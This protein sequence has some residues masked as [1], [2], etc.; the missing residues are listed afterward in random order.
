MPVGVLMS[1][2]IAEIYHYSLRISNKRIKRKRSSL[3]WCRAA[4]PGK[5]AIK[6]K[7]FKTQLRDSGLVGVRTGSGSKV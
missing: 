1:V 7:M 4:S 3:I 6:K 5:F 2:E